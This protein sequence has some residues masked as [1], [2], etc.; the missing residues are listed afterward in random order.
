MTTSCIVTNFQNYTELTESECE[1]LDSLEKSPTAYRRHSFV[2]EQGDS[3]DNFYTVRKGWACSFRDMEDGS[4][5]VLD[6]Y[7]PGDIIGL[8]EFAFRKRISGLMVLTNAE[9]CA[10]PKR[11]LTEVFARSSL[12]CN[13][14]FMIAAR[15]QAILVERLINLG[16]RTA[17]Q[18][19]AHFM[20][21]MSGRLNRTCADIVDCDHLPLT[22]VLIA[23]ALGLSSV[24]VNR[25]LQEL[26]ENKLILVGSSGINLLD[27]DGLRGLCG[28][29]PSY[30][31]EDMESMLA[32]VRDLQLGR[33]AHADSEE[34]WSQ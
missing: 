20:L 4:R 34:S 14:F 33:Q 27:K 6:I 22:Q 13:I 7:V 8:R 29:D 19:L 11:R 18:K 28:F 31:E 32:A 9:L 17:R 15:D 21:E 1:L 12:L 3:S 16:R 30:L 23:D 5:Q 24:H 25:S 2:W 10:F 26:R